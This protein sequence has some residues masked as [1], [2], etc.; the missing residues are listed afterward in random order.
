MQ[1]L[2]RIKETKQSYP[3]QGVQLRSS[4]SQIS[5]WFLESMIHPNTVGKTVNS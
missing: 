2:R 4:V 3:F 5:N 1:Y